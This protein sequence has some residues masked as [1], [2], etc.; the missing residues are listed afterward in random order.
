MDLLNKVLKKNWEDHRYLVT[1]IDLDPKEKAD[2]PKVFGAIWFDRETCK[3]EILREVTENPADAE[4]ILILEDGIGDGS[5]FRFL[6]AAMGSNLIPFT[7]EFK[8]GSIWRL[9]GK[10]MGDAETGKGKITFGNPFCEGEEPG[11]APP[12]S[13]GFFSEY[14]GGLGKAEPKRHAKAYVRVFEEGITFDEYEVVLKE[15][16]LQP[17]QEWLDSNSELPAYAPGYVLTYS[18]K[19]WIMPS[20]YIRFVDYDQLG[21]EAIKE[22]IRDQ[23]DMIKLIYRNKA[24]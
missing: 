12:V 22:A 1:R 21:E 7:P 17:R 3:D 2:N 19:R 10:L 4:M 5:S 20:R 16:T 15:S 24:M 14:T 13:L 6:F 11:E 23:C 8:V 18:D 9:A